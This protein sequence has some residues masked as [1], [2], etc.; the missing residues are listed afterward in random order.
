MKALDKR[1]TVDLVKLVIFMVVTTLATSVLVVTIGNLDF[2]TSREYK[3]EFS[4]AT[5]VVKGDDI[6]IAGV[7]VGT[8]KKVEIVER[9]RALVT[10]SVQETTSLS[11]A[12][13]ADIRYRNLVGQRYISLSNQIGDSSKLA[14]GATIPVSQTSPALDLTVLFNGFKPLFEALT[15]SDINQLSYEIVQVFQGEGGTLEGLLA[16]TASVTST[17]A[18]RDQIIGQLIDNLNEVLAHLGSRDEQLN[19]L[20]TTF[21]TFVG[22]LKDDRQAILG[23][24]DQISTLSVETASLV[25]GIRKPFVEDIK[26]LRAVAENLDRNKGELDRALQVLP[27]KLEKVGRTAIYGSW[28][29]FYLCQFQG[30]VTV[31]GVTVPVQYNTG[32]DRCALG[33]SIPFRERNPVVIGA[34]SLAVVAGLI[35]AAFNA[36]NLPIIGGGDV[37]YAAF[38]EAGGLKANDEVRVAGVR[39]GKVEKVELDGDHVKVTFRIEEGAEFG[40]ETR[41]DIKVKTLLGAMYL[42]LAPA[43]SGQLPEGGEIP[44]ARTSSPYDVVQAFSGLAETSEDIDT[45]QLAQ[46]LTTLADLTRNTPEE[47]QAALDGVSRLSTNVAAK[48]SQINELLGNLQNVAEVLD[49]R[50]QDIIGLMRDSDV[51]FRALVKRRDAVHRLL[52]ST[53][54]LSTELTKLVKQSRADL[55]PALT[56]LDT[57]VGVL[58]KNEDNIDNSLRLMAP[59]YRVFANTLGNGPWFDTY[60]QNIPPVPQVG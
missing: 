22:G 11:K 17:L 38:S 46:A 14:E 58:N 37:Y 30:K 31:A 43:G 42:S 26:H 60:I 59:F 39:V 33:C 57:V 50:D 7:K 56:H 5:G 41:A 2:G 29:N 8:V 47:F 21:R 53:T 34:I 15:P 32:S 10:F 49:A 51:L 16:H 23:S 48:S 28:F 55:K 4:D 35:L 45:D 25:E 19:R 36:Q 24:L 27:I 54:T 3:A 12:T 9:T 44:V 6:R 20:I 18:D 13:R 1:T 52:V 40:K